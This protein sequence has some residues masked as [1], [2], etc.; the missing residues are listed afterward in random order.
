MRLGGLFSHR[1]LRRL[2]LFLVLPGLAGVAVLA[3]VFLVVAGAAQPDFR[4]IHDPVSP[5]HEAI[6]NQMFISRLFLRTR[7]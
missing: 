5:E 3:V 2:L 7:R 4:P 6:I 1:F